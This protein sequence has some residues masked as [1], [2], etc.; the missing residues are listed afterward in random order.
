MHKA[1]DL[2]GGAVRRL[3]RPEATVAWLTSSWPS[4]VGKML[5]AH[6]R[7]LRCEDGCLEIAADRKDWKSQLEPMTAEFCAR[8]NQAWGG[9]LVSE[10]KFVATPRNA[11]KTATNGDKPGP[12]RA[13]R[14]SDN[15]HLPFIRRRR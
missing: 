12:K 1:G 13:T 7:P 3:K 8:I 10:V 15:E 14:E 4:I 6:T 5:A 2:L 11:M 9:K